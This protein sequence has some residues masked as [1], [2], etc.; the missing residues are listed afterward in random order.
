MWVDTVTEGGQRFITVLRKEDVDAAR[1]R[2]AKREATKL[3][4]KML[5]HTEA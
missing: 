3:R 4:K 1:H 5:S 2:Q